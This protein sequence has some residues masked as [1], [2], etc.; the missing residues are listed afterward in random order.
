MSDRFDGNTGGFLESEEEES[1]GDD[2]GAP[3]PEVPDPAGALNVPDMGENYDRAD[4]ALK[5]Q[6]WKLVFVYKIGILATCIGG[7]VAV[8]RGSMVAAQV[9]AIGLVAL[10]YALYETRNL[11]RRADAGEFDHDPEEEEQ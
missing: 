3:S 1:A 2:L 10:G 9:A 8:F 4:P 6:F 11:K 7:T 5:T